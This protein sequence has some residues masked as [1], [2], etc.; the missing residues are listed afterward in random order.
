MGVHHVSWHAIAS[1]VEDEIVVASALSWLVGSDDLVEIE[2]TDSY[3]GSK[4]SVITSHIN[5]KRKATDSLS[6][7]GVEVLE[8]VLR[9][10]DE[11]LD[12][13]KTL[14]IRLDMIDLISGK[15]KLKYSENRPSI[16]G[17]TKLEVYPGDDVGKV[18]EETIKKAI[19]DALNLRLPEKSEDIL[20][21]SYMHVHVRVS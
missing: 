15:L 1:G 19:N 5:N 14:H 13:E 8:E 3:H 21:R 20:T 2:T 10:I 12:E 7:L 18:A 9:T 17:K 4:F 11:R 16:K 6:R